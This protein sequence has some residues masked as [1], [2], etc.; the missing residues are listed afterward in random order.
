MYYADLQMRVSARSACLVAVTI[1]VRD[2][3]KIPL[4]HGMVG[5]GACSPA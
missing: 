3:V 2:G 1:L 5:L 4:S